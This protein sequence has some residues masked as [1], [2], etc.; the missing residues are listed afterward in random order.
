MKRKT[1]NPAYGNKKPRTYCENCEELT[2]IPLEQLNKVGEKTEA[3]ECTTAHGIHK[4][5]MLKLGN[6]NMKDKVVL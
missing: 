4:K 2:A 6:C 5:E 3:S 1:E